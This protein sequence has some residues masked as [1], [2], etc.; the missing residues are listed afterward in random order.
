MHDQNF[1]LAKSATYKFTTGFCKAFFYNNLPSLI[2]EALPWGRGGGYMFPELKWH[3]SR[4]LL[5][6]NCGFL[7]SLFPKIARVPLFPLFLSLCSPEKCPY[8][9]VPQNPREGLIYRPRYRLPEEISCIQYLLLL[10][11]LLLLSVY[12]HYIAAYSL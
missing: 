12:E 9:P 7:C 8:S 1:G 3:C 4:V 11:L 2:Y 10:F 6:Q 5:K